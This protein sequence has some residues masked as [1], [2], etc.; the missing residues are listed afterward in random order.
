MRDLICPKCG[1][2]LAFEN[3]LCLSCDS[4]LGF[5]LD[6]MALLV[7]ATGEESSQ[8]GF[9][10]A[11]KYELCANLHLAECNWLVEKVPV[12]KL[13]TSCALT[14]TRPNDADTKAQGTRA[15]SKDLSNSIAPGRH[16]IGLL[17]T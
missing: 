14:R 9:V 15:S 1:Q 5:S 10:D 4:P 8:P 2:H 11:D 17:W 16:T 6:D 7:I 13:C 12:R 3:S